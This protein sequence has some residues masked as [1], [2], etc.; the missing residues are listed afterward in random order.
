MP[1]T[2]RYFDESQ[3]NAI[4][5]GLAWL[6]FLGALLAWLVAASSPATWITSGSAVALLAAATSVISLALR[7]PILPSLD[8][9]SYRSVARN[10]AVWLLGTCANLNWLG[11]FIL[12]SPHGADALPALL[13]VLTAE[14]GF[15]ATAWQQSALPWL[16]Q[17][18]TSFTGTLTGL[19]TGTELHHS[20]QRHA[21]QR[22]ATAQLPMTTHASD[23][24][25]E[26][27][28]AEDPEDCCQS[29]LLE[30]DAQL[31]E[32]IDRRQVHGVN[33]FDQPFWSGEIRVHFCSDQL[34]QQ[35]TVGFSPPFFSAPQVDWE[36]ESEEAE[37]KLVNCTPTGMRLE[38][39]RFSDREPLIFPLQWYAAEVELGNMATA[40]PAK[41]VLP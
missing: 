10:H 9:L 2:P 19:G 17:A 26:E 13:L 24:T 41:R 22:H 38:I 31:G 25:L 16:N 35:V 6:W 18:W 27:N 7:L 3:Q 4:W 29:E 23:P 15:V 30:D 34:I 32:S 20:T 1:T 39:R 40:S 14:I 11:F 28:S 5:L 37:V 33:E 36:C 21:T 8:V 12:Q